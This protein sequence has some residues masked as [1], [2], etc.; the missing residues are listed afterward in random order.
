MCAGKLS[1]K[2]EDAL[3]QDP[4]VGL[5]P[6][7]LDLPESDHTVGTGGFGADADLDRLPLRRLLGASLRG[8]GRSTAL[9]LPWGLP[10][11]QP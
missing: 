11:R 2:G 10:Y 8:G 6:P 9:L 3:L 7:L 5:Q 1:T 4:E